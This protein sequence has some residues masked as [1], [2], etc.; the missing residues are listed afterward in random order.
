MTA[1]RYQTMTDINT[2]CI[3]KKCSKF[4][5]VECGRNIKWNDKCKLTNSIDLIRNMLYPSYNALV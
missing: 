4:P 5:N 3:I 2:M 1:I